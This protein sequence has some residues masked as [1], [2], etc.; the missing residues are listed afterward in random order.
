MNKLKKIKP[1]AP[2]IIPPEN[3]WE[4][5]CLYL[6][7]VAYNPSNPIHVSTFYSGF[8]DKKG[9]P[10]GYNEVHSPGMHESS[11]ISDLYY[12]KVLKKIATEKELQDSSNTHK[13]VNELCL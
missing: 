1:L 12:L 3:G 9:N 13:M 11:E 2:R 5:G 4:R 7:E 10:C 6:V 8:L